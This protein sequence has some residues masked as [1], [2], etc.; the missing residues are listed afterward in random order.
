MLKLPQLLI[1]TVK[2]KRYSALFSWAVTKEPKQT[3]LGLAG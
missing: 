3:G 1:L 2:I